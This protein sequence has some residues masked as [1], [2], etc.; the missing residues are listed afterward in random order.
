MIMKTS[1]GRGKV[2]ISGIG[3]KKHVVVMDGAYTEDGKYFIY[4][5][6]LYWYIMDIKSGLSIGKEDNYTTKIGL[7]QKYDE[8]TKDFEKK[9]VE[10]KDIYQK[11]CRN[12]KRLCKE[13][14]LKKASE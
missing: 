9:I 4:K 2:L 6:S 14:D 10:H 8:L 7:L 12:Y 13:Y 1:R 11:I 5:T 3:N